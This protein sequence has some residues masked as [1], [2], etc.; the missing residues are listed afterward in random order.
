M[1]PFEVVYVVTVLTSFAQHV[2]VFNILTPDLTY[3][4]WMWWFYYFV[5]F[6]DTYLLIS[7][8]LL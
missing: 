2:F 4:E 8:I 1:F 5:F 6:T 7:L 3:G